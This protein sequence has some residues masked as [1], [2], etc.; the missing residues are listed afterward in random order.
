[1]P[2]ILPLY[3]PVVK[4][5]TPTDRLLT[6]KTV[7][8]RLSVSRRTV[9]RLFKAGRLQRVKVGHATRVHPA[10]LARFLNP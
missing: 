2:S 5:S 8:A 10:E 6:V 1:M 9:F 4:V 7:A 3:C